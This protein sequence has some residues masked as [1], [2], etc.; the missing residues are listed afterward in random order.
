MT[1][2]GAPEVP[3]PFVVLQVFDWWLTSEALVLAAW[4][5]TDISD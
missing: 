2:E 3:F 4:Q 1:A 5:E